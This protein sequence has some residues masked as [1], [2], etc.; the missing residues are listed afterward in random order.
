MKTTSNGYLGETSGCHS[1][2]ELPNS[3]GPHLQD[4]EV[5]IFQ[6]TNYYTNWLFS[7]YGIGVTRLESIKFGE[8]R[9]NS[10]DFLSIIVIFWNYLSQKYLYN[11]IAF[12]LHWIS[13]LESTNIPAF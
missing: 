6:L 10:L 4:I 13:W 5:E 9:L 11:C 1:S 7:N 2:Q 8:A 3:P 12:F